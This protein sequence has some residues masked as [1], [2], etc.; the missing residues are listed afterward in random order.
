[1]TQLKTFDLNLL[2][3][4][5]ALYE[6]QNTTKAADQLGLTQSAVSQ[7]LGRLRLHMNDNLFYRSPTGMTPTPRA[8]EMI[9]PIRQAVDSIT[10]L[11]PQKDFEP[12]KSN[13]QFRLGMLDYGVV[14]IAPNLVQLMEA[15]STQMSF[16]IF[17]LTS[18][19]AL[20]RLIKG[21]LDLITGPYG[22]LPN[23]VDRFELFSDG[24]VL[25]ARQDHPGLKKKLT[26][27]ILFSLDYVQI[28]SVSEL[29]PI[30]EQ[31]RAD[32]NSGRNRVVTVPYF[33][34]APF[35]VGGSDMV[36]IFPR[37]PAELY[38]QACN[39]SLH[40]I[41][42][43]MDPLRICAV[44]HRRSRNDAAIIWLRDVICKMFEK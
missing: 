9:E 13:R 25:I 20:K 22:E 4:F 42:I 33:A 35:I 32:Q 43:K 34:G 40:E 29:N 28:R 12:S 30:F 6:F 44:T 16:E 23:D 37:G 26:K 1:M 27:Q 38:A 18:D 3:V 2:K 41:P 7:A 24:Y 14:M 39:L 19:V 8:E 5:V 17:H 11:L 21:E 31:I 36:A 10:V 15:Y